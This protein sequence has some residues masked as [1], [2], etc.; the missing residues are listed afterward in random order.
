MRVKIIKCSEINKWYVGLI[1]E[2]FEVDSRLY[3]M[4]GEEGLDK[5]KRLTG[6]NW[7]NAFI[8]TSDC[9]VVEKDGYSFKPIH[10]C[11]EDGVKALEEYNTKEAAPF[12]LPADYVYVENFFVITPDGKKHRL[13]PVDEPAPVIPV[14]EP[15]LK[16]FEDCLFKVDPKYYLNNLSTVVKCNGPQMRGDVRDHNLLPTL[17]NGK[18]IQAAIKLFVIHAALVNNYQYVQAVEH[19]EICFH[20]DE[21]HGIY[22]A[23]VSYGL[24]TQ[25]IFPTE[26]LAQKAIDIDIDLWRMYF[27]LI[28]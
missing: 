2:E 8:L 16:T 15:E 27:G 13:V 1:G 14:K 22:P 9:E 7:S 26:E 20:D 11:V 10:E 18:Q 23:A 12:A 17:N 25:F 21:K 19:W 5:M 4:K 24:A 3:L 28:D 6:Y